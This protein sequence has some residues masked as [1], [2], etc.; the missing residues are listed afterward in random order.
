MKQGKGVK[1][2]KWRC[3]TCKKVA[4]PDEYLSDLRCKKCGAYG[5]ERN[6]EK[7]EW[8]LTI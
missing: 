5:L 6:T 4:Y 8:I 3:G 1:D 2:F 7:R